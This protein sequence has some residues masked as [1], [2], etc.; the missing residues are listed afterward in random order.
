MR[1]GIALNQK[2][3]VQILSAD[4]EED[5]EFESEYLALSAQVV[6]MSWPINLRFFWIHANQDLCT[7][8]TR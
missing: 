3:A 8:R 6:R 2:K 4:G 7:F 5:E 1:A